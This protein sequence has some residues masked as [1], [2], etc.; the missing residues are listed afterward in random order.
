MQELLG[1]GEGWKI[2]A[3]LRIKCQERR[4]KGVGC[5]TQYMLGVNTFSFF[6]ANW[7]RR[8][9]LLVFK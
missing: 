8:E 9:E 1:V 4:Q 2:R 3:G 5:K 6:F 7:K